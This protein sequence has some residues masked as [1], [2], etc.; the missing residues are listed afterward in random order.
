MTCTLT[1]V[2]YPATSVAERSNFAANPSVETNANGWNAFAP[3]ANG[4]VA[5]FGPYPAGQ[6][7]LPGGA[8]GGAC[9][10]RVTWNSQA[11]AI[12][13]GLYYQGGTP[14]TP[15]QVYTV[16]V[17][18][19]CSTVQRL[20]VGV[21][22]LN[23]A[24]TTVIA[25]SVGAATVVAGSSWVRLSVTTTAAPPGAA[26]AR[27]FIYAQTGASGSVWGTGSF[28]DADALLFERGDQLL[29][30]FDGNTSSVGLIGRRYQWAGVANLSASTL[31]ARTPTAALQVT[32][33][34]VLSYGARREAAT[35]LHEVIGRPD[36]VPA[37]RPMRTRTGGMDLFFLTYA[38]A[39]AAAALYGLGG[40]V[41]LRDTDRPGQDM[42][43]VATTAEV[44][45]ADDE[46]H[47]WIT[48]VQYAEVY[49]TA[50]TW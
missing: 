6:H 32:P 25:S 3:D 44:V 36:P 43:H 21:D 13:G 24:V 8:P 4:T 48:R 28:L 15:G 29:P 23:A 11:T 46:W 40:V 37:L 9:F 16:S 1:A 5:R 17:Y 20:A 2:P 45:P 34:L 19:R 33:R 35:V 50:T 49:G 41:L 39:A 30:Y 12:G 26:Q 14:V 18:V 7:V 38:A 10:V 31:M 47:R 42:Y 27:V 22:W